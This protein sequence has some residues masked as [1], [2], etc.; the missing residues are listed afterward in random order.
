MATSDVLQRPVA[1]DYEFLELLGE[2]NMHRALLSEIK[3]V[4][5]SNFLVKEIGLAELRQ[6]SAQTQPASEVLNAVT[7]LLVELRS[8][9]GYDKSTYL[10]HTN[11]VV[12][13]EYT[14][15]VG[16]AQQDNDASSGSVADET[17]P[18]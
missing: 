3:G 10:K 4:E 9:I 8:L 7:G 5:A 17:P 12:D 6:D 1:H 15:V 11:V 16:T 14:Q 2:A 13:A 18:T